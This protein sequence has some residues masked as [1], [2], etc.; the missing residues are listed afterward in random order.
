MSSAT[1][2]T[3]AV[4]SVSEPTP[5]ILDVLETHRRHSAENYPGESDHSLSAEDHVSEDLHLLSAW[6][7]AVCVG[8]VGL[9]IMDASNAELK[10]MHVL[11]TARGAGVG[12]EA[13]AEAAAQKE[14]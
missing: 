5:E 4:R 13:D 3:I 14:R 9:R 8:I 1:P 10:S 2:D 12:R 6:L 7:G 11:E